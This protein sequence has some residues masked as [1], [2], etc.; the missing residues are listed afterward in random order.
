MDAGEAM[1]LVLSILRLVSMSEH[2]M[3]LALTAFRVQS[4]SELGH[5]CY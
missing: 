5:G 4:Q 3:V 1:E 2:E